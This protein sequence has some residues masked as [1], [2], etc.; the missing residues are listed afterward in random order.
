V[1]THDFVQIV[2]Q[3][4]GGWNGEAF[5]SSQQS[6]GK[7]RADPEPN[8]AVHIVGNVAGDDA[9]EIDGVADELPAFLIRMSLRAWRSTGL[10]CSD[11]HFQRGYR[12]C[13]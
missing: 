1:L 12:P 13:S 2:Q 3:P 6:P 7:D 10:R 4:Q 11:G 5:V 9:G 8:G